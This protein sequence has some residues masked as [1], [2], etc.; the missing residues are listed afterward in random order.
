MDW[1]RHS[2]P[3]M[4]GRFLDERSPPTQD[5][6]LD[7]RHQYSYGRELIAYAR[8]SGG[9]PYGE[10]VHTSSESGDSVAVNYPSFDPSA[11]WRQGEAARKSQRVPPQY[12]QPRYDYRQ[13][14]SHSAE[15]V[16]RRPVTSRKDSLIPPRAWGSDRKTRFRDRQFD[17]LPVQ[18][19]STV[20]RGSF[21]EVSSSHDPDID[22]PDTIYPFER[23]GSLKRMHAEQAVHIS[24][25]DVAESVSV[26]TPGET[27]KRNPAVVKF[28]KHKRHQ[29]AKN[30]TP[31]WPLD[32]FIAKTFTRAVVILLSYG[33]AWAVL[34]DN[35]LP[36]SLLFS[37]SLLIL[38]S[39]VGGFISKVFYLPPL[40]GMILVGFL[41]KNI[42][43][44]LDDKSGNSTN[45]KLGNVTAND[46]SNNMTTRCAMEAEVDCYALDDDWSSILRGVALVIILTRA[47]LSLN[48][49]VLK[50]MKFVVARLAFLPSLAE[51]CVEAVVAHFLLDM[52]WEWAFMTGYTS[53]CQLTVIFYVTLVVVLFDCRFVIAAISPAVVVLGLLGL[54]KHGYGTAQGIPTLLIAAATGDDVLD[55]SGFGICLGIAFAEGQSIVITFTCRNENVIHSVLLQGV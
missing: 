37:F 22:R 36:C 30:L 26:K 42:P 48:V 33:A 9:E 31:H 7:D 24:V 8:R 15:H 12:N 35:I 46:T 20:R 51:A 53:I 47:G 4:D 52:P 17:S 43:K 3:P 50:K 29:L 41:F 38:L 16:T 10:A 45:A 21:S 18:S 11:A 1:R 23:H 39:A 54:Q 40:V 25:S 44:F 34:G 2:H 13:D 28:L 14:M 19:E 6:P 55:I 32:G 49:G 27:E 5:G